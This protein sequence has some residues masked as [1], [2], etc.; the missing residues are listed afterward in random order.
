MTVVVFPVLS[1]VMTTCLDERQKALSV[2][3]TVNRFQG[4]VRFSLQIVADGDGLAA[5]PFS[6][7]SVRVTRA[8]A[9]GTH[10]DGLGEAQWQFAL[11][12]LP[13]LSDNHLSRDVAPVY[14]DQLE[15]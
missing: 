8:N 3:V 5:P 14:N 9:H 11:G 15:P 2:I 13:P 1:V 7:V 4:L 12:G 10:V 6:E